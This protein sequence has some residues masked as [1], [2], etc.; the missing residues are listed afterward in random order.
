MADAGTGEGVLSPLEIGGAARY[1]VLARG[2]AAA[3]R[4][5]AA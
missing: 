2:V 3:R 4:G 5:G 1:P